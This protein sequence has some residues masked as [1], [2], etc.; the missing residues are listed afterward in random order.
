[1]LYFPAMNAREGMRRLGLA[2]GALGACIGLFLAYEQGSVLLNH[3][4]RHEAFQQLASMPIVQSELAAV[5][6]AVAAKPKEE[7][8]PG[9]K[10][11]AP[12]KGY[13][14]EGPWVY[15][16]ALAA[17]SGSTDGWPVGKDGIATLYFD[18]KILTA[19]EK[20]T[21]ERF[22]DNT[23]PPSFSDYL[24]VIMLPIVG[25]LLPWGA[26]SLLT[27]IGAGFFKT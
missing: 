25:F 1:M 8:P 6:A 27:W 14:F 9:W 5:N 4:S 20:D 11:V 3:R 10:P 7:E 21:G 19:I 13:K 24:E 18:N 22:Y 26:I 15:Y 12:P 23:E 16:S 2:M 17:L